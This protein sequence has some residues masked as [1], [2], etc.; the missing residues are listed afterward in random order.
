MTWTAGTFIFLLGYIT[1]C[2]SDA[3]NNTITVRLC[4][5]KRSTS[6]FSIP[7][8][9]PCVKHTITHLQTCDASI[10]EP[11]L[12]HIKITAFLC[13]METQLFTTNTYFLGEQVLDK[14]DKIQK[15]TS[16]ADCSEMIRN[17]NVKG[18]GRLTRIHPNIYAT[19]NKFKP[20]YGWMREIKT[21]VSNVY[22]EYTHIYYDFFN[23]QIRYIFAEKML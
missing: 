5:Q 18:I 6:L 17:K 15:P 3:T 12:S 11:V 1:H 8:P 9:Q 16:L 2:R 19:S 10:F 21:V 20:K 7:T 14:G 23:G 22:S 13:S 4:T